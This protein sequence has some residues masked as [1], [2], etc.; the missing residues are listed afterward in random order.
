MLQDRN[1][2]WGSEEPSRDYGRR[3][4]TE[5]RGREAV[6]KPHIR[7]IQPNYTQSD[8]RIIRLTCRCDLDWKSRLR[9]LPQPRYGD[10]PF[11]H[12]KAIKFPEEIRLLR[13][14]PNANMVSRSEWTFYP[15]LGHAAPFHEGKRCLFDG[16]H[17]RRS[18][19]SHS[20]TTLESVMG[21]KK[22]GER[23]SSRHPAEAPKPYLSPEY[24]TDFHKYGSTLPAIGF[25]VSYVEKERIK[26]R[27]A[28]ILEVK[29]LNEW[30]PAASIF[31]L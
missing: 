21:Q 7:H 6:Y 4:F 19:R 5:T 17:H 30:N 3:H 23:E 31:D 1:T 15:N 25:G 28:D 22:R 9:R 8:W 12:I 16:T 29:Q 10:A 18:M 24:T 14:F 27:E 20:H 13:S 26:Q 2:I 11:P